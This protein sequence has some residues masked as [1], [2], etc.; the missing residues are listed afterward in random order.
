MVFTPTGPAIKSFDDRAEQLSID[1]VE[2]LLV[3]IQ[4]LER[5]PPHH[6]ESRG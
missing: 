5:A 1:I 2:A 4:K 3:A 6:G